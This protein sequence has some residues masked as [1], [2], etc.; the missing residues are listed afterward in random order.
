MDFGLF[1]SFFDF[2]SYLGDYVAMIGEAFSYLPN[3]FKDYW[4]VILLGV[5]VIGLFAILI[6]LVS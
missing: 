5:I 3:L 4:T 1:D 2:T 6:R